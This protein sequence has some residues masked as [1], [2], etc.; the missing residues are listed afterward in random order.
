MIFTR[1]VLMILGEELGIYV[2]R[3]VEERDG[4]TKGKRE[5]V[6]EK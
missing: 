2:F 4:V 5:K 6:R 1:P 3:E